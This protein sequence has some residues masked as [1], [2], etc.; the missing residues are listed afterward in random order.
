[1]NPITIALIEDSAPDREI[2]RRYLAAVAVNEQFEFIE[3]D[4]GE[5]GIALCR[6]R[7][8]DCILLDYNLPDMTGLEVLQRLSLEMDPVPVVM[9]TGLGDEMLAVGALKAGAQDYLPKDRLSPESLL[10]AVHYTVERVHLLRQVH[11]QN[12]ELMETNRQLQQSNLA[13][14]AASK[15]KSEFLANMSHEIRTPMNSIIGMTELLLRT[16]LNTDQQE[17][18]TTIYTSCGLLLD[19]VNDVLDFSKIE[20]REMALHPMPVVVE[21]L[22]TEILQLL[23][24]KAREN[25]VELAV[26]AAPDVPRAVMGDPVRLRQ[27]LLNLTGNAVKFTHKGHICISV[28]RVGKSAHG[29]VRLRFS[30]QDTGIGIPKDKQAEIFSEFTQADGSTTR[31]YGGTGLGLSISKKLVQLMNGEIGVVSEPGEGSLFWFEVTFPVYQGIERAVT[32]PETVRNKRVLIVDDYHINQRVFSEY[33]G[34]HDIYSA[35]ASSGRDALAMIGAA[36]NGSNPFDLIL[37]DYQMP[38]MNGEQL[39]RVINSLNLQPRPKCLLVTAL[40]K[41]EDFDFL[42]DAGFS[43]YLLKPVYEHALIESLI[44]LFAKEGA[45]TISPPVA[46]PLPAPAQ[47][48]ARVLVVEDYPPNQR[49]AESMLEMM[50]C[51]V[52]IATD[53]EAALKELEARHDSYDVVFMDC[54]MPGLDGYETTRAIRQTPW[55]KR[56]PIIAMTA[57]ALEGDRDKCL[58][59]GMDDYL[60]KPV[61]FAEVERILSGLLLKKAA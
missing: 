54:Q 15:A 8:P 48:G 3:A 43:G 16:A 2:Y 44:K 42:E 53:G 6:E 61:R 13:A 12:A 39:A 60:S 37:I 32:V 56:M 10:R 24:P 7:R 5:E 27:I 29:E 57:N 50:G 58:D 19:L 25:Q 17:Y 4:M 35:T 55:G 49:M 34:R 59:A 45:E 28:D 9:L 51:D 23:Q 18:A 11:E 1:M 52:H 14:A 22:V 41:V 38:H 26:R 36:A 31:R 33:L 20:A 30:V 47:F 21:A 40:G 46:A